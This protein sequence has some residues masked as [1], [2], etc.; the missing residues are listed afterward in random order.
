L[1][2]NFAYEWGGEGTST[3]KCSDIYI[4][5]EPFSEPETLAVKTFIENKAAA[6]VN[7]TS[8]FAVHSYS[9][10]WLVPWGWTYD[11]P[12]TYDELKE[13]GQ[14]GLDALT[15][16]HGTKYQIGTVTEILS[17]CHVNQLLLYI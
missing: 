5:P 7:W 1:K 6:G 14:V 12:P 8:Y 9:Q 16:V 3:D 4:G 15:P 13:F 17:K 2:R 11:L 10:M